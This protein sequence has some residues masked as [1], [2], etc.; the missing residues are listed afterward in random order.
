MY[1][2]AD[3]E[4]LERKGVF[5]YDYL[6]SFTRLDK[7]KLPPREAFV[8]KLGGIECSQADY[9]HAQH[10]WNNFQCQSLKEY[11]ALYLLSDICLLA[12]EFQAF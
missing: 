12:D 7:P 8:N 2:E 1:P 9:A 11:K 4:L 5:C 6:D 3:L 10:V